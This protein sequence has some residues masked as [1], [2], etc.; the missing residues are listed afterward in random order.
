M[1]LDYARSLFREFENYLRV[2]VGLDEE[3]GGNLGTAFASWSTKAA[4]SSIPEV[5]NFYHTCKG[6]YLGLV[7]EVFI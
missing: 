3:D 4:L 7:F 2:V 1:L 5:I 6:L